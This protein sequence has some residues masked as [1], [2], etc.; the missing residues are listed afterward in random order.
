MHARSSMLRL[1]A[2]GGLALSVAGCIRDPDPFTFEMD[3]VAVHFIL[4]AGSDSVMALVER[5]GE[6][7]ED[8]EV[9]LIAGTDTTALAFSGPACAGSFGPNPSPGCHRAELPRPI[10]TGATYGLEVVLADGQRITGSTTVP[11]PLSV[12]AP[13]PGEA[14]VAD[15][16]HTETCYAT[17]LEQPP[18]Y[19][20]VVAFVVRW[21][22]A[23]DRARLF[24]YVRPVRTFLG[25][26]VYG[27]AEGCTLGYHG[28]FGQ[29][30]AF[31]GR[32][33]PTTADSIRILVPNIQCPGELAPGRFDSIQAE[34]RVHLWNED[35]AAYLEI[36]FGRGQSVRE[37]QVSA[38]L[39]GAWGVFGA[40]TPT[41]VP[42]TI[43]RDPP[44]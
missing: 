33:T 20:P 25:D 30:F 38:G 43:V 29:Q 15:C 44:L 11:M 6:A 24:G 9:R 31:G 23:T 36:V 8:A 21:A 4:E 12:T 3:D 41:A 32:D 19:L 40:I 39:D 42:V 27:P 5:P 10:E 1:A 35:Y 22:E 34:A 28:F 13:G 37:A 18:Y 2:L 17:Y 16:G 7:V 14:V 26:R